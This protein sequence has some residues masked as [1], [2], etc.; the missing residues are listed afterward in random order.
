MKN[1]IIGIG[2]LLWDVFPG[3]KVIGGAP[4]NFAYHVSQ[5]GYNGY[6][7]SAIGEDLLGKEILSGRKKTELFG[8][9]YRLSHRNGA[10]DA[11]RSRCSR[12]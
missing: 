8:R 7:V 9:Y 6:A 1:T 11:D 12:I 4:A 5:F 10:S 2:E 3:R